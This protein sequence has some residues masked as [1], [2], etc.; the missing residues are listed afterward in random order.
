MNLHVNALCNFGSW[1]M[2]FLMMNLS[3][4]EEIVLKNKTS[5]TKKKTSKT[6]KVSHNLLTTYRL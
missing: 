6:I 3:K 5:E 4:G 2:S 1:D